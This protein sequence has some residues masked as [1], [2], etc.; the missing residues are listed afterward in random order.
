MVTT[1]CGSS[2]KHTRTLEVGNDGLINL[3]HISD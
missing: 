1:G 3:L 2:V